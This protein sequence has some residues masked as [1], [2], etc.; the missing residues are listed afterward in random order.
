MQL[1]ISLLQ[2]FTMNPVILSSAVNNSGCIITV[3]TTATSG[4][5][6]INMEATKP[7]LPTNTLRIWWV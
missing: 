6:Y 4:E 2:D 5:P 3:L 1:E 7:M